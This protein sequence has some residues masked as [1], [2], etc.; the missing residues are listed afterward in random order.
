MAG[1]KYNLGPDFG[2]F[3]SQ[4]IICEFYLCEMLEIVASYYCMKFQVKLMI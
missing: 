3:T 4:K 1:K 2:L